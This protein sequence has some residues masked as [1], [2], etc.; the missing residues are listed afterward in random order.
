M[1]RLPRFTTAGSYRWWVLALLF[2]ASFLNY[3]DRQTVSVL[4]TTLKA[5]YGLDDAAYAL[6]VNVFTG[7]YAAAYIGSGWLV[8]R[9]GPRH[10]LALFASVWSL[11]TVACGAAATFLQLVLMRGLLGL[12]EPGNHPVAIRVATAWAPARR[13][14]LFM[15]LC[16]FGSSVGAVAAPPIIA[17]L[18]LVYHWRVAF[19]VPGLVGLLLAAVWWLTYRDPA[20]LETAGKSKG[21]VVTSLRWA[22]LWRHPAVWG[23]VLCRLISDPVWYFC[24]FWLPGYLQEQKGATMADLGWLG[25]LPFLA[26][27]VGALAMAALSDRLA[28]GSADPLAARKRLLLLVSM[29]GPICMAVPQAPNLITTLALFCVIAIVCNSWL[30]TLAPIIAE[31]FPLGNVAS[32]WGIAGAFGATGAMVFNYV[33]GHAAETIGLTTLFVIMGVLH[34]CAAVLLH[35]LVRRRATDPRPEVQAQNA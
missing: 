12:A 25:W 35:L 23:I 18:A 19:V 1:P 3:F 2:G 24:L 10:A 33:I 14:G 28:N 16:G 13:R 27:N 5:E 31:V 32:V 6:L 34:P 26:A 22:A 21:A 9:M 7:C 8:D 17:F 4:K 20:P 15:S 30:S 29:A 11:A